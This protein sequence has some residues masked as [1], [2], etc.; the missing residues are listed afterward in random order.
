MRTDG[1]VSLDH[2]LRT[3]LEHKKLIAVVAGLVT[4]IGFCALV[5]LLLGILPGPIVELAKAS[6]L[7]IL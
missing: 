4:A 3:L 5:T 2:Y 6:L 1:T 7:P